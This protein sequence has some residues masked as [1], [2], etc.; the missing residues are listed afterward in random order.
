[1][2]GKFEDPFPPESL[3]DRRQLNEAEYQAWTHYLYIQRE[4]EISKEYP[5]SSWEPSRI[6]NYTKRKSEYDNSGYSF[7]GC[8]PLGFGWKGVW[9]AIK[10]TDVV[11]VINELTTKYLIEKRNWNDAVEL[12]PSVYGASGYR[13]F[14]I[15]PP[16]EGVIFVKPLGQ[17]KLNDLYHRGTG[18]EFNQIFDA[19]E[20]NWAS[21]SQDFGD[22]YFLLLDR[23]SS[24]TCFV[25]WK[26]GKVVRAVNSHLSG[27]YYEIGSPLAGENR[28]KF[29]G[30]DH[31]TPDDLY[32]ASA[33]WRVNSNYIRPL[34]P[35][36]KAYCWYVDA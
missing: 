7:E 10:S 15:T 23:V 18:K 1:M 2:V 6:E 19:V 5:M 27:Y 30:V 9:I 28:T 13:A 35:N 21:I 34:Q 3:K 12:L 31:M 29:I 17:V 22:V 11:G 36:E 8:T 33:L 16:C 26:T 32:T 20:H 4:D 14:K 25:K 24:R